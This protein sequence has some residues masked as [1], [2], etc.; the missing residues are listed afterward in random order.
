MVDLVTEKNALHPGWGLRRL[1]LRMGVALRLR[2]LL[3]GTGNADQYT[4][5][6][7]CQHRAGPNGHIGAAADALLR[8]HRLALPQLPG[9][10]V[11]AEPSDL[12]HFPG[13][14]ISDLAT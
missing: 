2:L 7:N 11:P 8:R 14:E 3:D 12:A 5:E 13:I 4:P 6:T 1:E 10:V 9:T